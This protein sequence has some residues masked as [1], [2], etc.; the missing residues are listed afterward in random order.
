MFSCK[1][2][3]IGRFDKKCSHCMLRTLKD[4]IWDKSARSTHH[5]LGTHCVQIRSLPACNNIHTYIKRKFSVNKI[6]TKRKDVKQQCLITCIG[7]A[8]DIYGWCSPGELRDIITLVCTHK[9][10]RED[11]SN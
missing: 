9:R 8:I 5:K 6:W 1:V 3:D 11:D 4:R 2:D 7:N 10:R